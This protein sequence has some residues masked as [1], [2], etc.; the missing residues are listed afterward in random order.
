MYV[1]SPSLGIG[2]EGE[3][4]DV[5]HGNGLTVING[6]DRMYHFPHSMTL[7]DGFSQT[8]SSDGQNITYEEWKEKR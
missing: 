4:S 6:F 3:D 7:F 1:L 8:S 5:L 2:I